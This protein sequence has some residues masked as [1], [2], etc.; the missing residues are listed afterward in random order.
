M[1]MV[2]KLRVDM[3]GVFEKFVDGEAGHLNTPASS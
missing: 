2:L 3:G 1:S